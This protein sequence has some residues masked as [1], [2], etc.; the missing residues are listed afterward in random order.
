MPP[1]SKLVILDANV[2]ITAH[3][4]GVWA[5]ICNKYDVHVTKT[6]VKDEVRHFTSKKT[7]QKVSIDLKPQIENKTITEI[8]G[9]AQSLHRLF[10][11]T[12]SLSETI[13]PGETEAIALLLDKKFEEFRFCTGDQT[14][15]KIMS[16]LSISHMGLS[17]EKLLTDVGISKNGLHPSYSEK[18]FKSRVTDGFREKSYYVKD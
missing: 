16:A 2:I 1:K 9:D 7:S 13:D 12:K 5:H 4:L 17:M 18:A 8:E 10:S 15:I 14:A 6:V 11:K 3:E